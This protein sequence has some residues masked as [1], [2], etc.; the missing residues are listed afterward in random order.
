MGSNQVVPSYKWRMGLQR[1][2][3]S[4]VLGSREA[5][6]VQTKEVLFLDLPSHTVVLPSEA[7]ASETAVPKRSHFM[8]TKEQQHP[9]RAP[10]RACGFPFAQTTSTNTS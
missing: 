4:R 10:T 6:Q 7:T 3:R 8:G 9:L 5:A 2:T 1:E